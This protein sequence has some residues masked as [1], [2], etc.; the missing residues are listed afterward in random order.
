VFEMETCLL[1]S[2]STINR[3]YLCRIMSPG[4]CD[5][6]RAVD[7]LLTVNLSEIIVA[8]AGN[9]ARRAKPPVTNAA[10]RQRLARFKF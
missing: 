3:P 9:K 4:G 1:G 8:L 5:F 7:M 10:V 6:D 2:R